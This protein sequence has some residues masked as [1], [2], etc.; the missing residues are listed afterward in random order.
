MNFTQFLLILR[1]RYRIILMTLLV[2]V[3]TTLVVSLLLPKTY[4]AST[5]LVLNY[6]GA[7]AVTGMALPAQLMPGYMPTQID[8][9][10]SRRVALKVV[11]DL[12]LAEG[13]AVQEQ[14]MK[15]VDGKG[16]VRDWLADA[17]L[18]GVEVL[19]SRE[20]SVLDINY[21]ATDPQFAAAIAN[22]F[23]AAYQQISIQLKVEPAQKAS[24]YFNEQIKQLREK[25]EQA[26]NKLSTYQQEHGIVSADNRLDVESARLNELS[27]QLVMAQGQSME[28]G[29][30]QRQAQSA[31]ASSPDVMANPL[32]QNIKVNLSMAEVKFAE[33]SQKL[34]KNHPQYQSA[35]SEVDKLRS[36]LEEQIKLASNGVAGNALILQQREAEIRAALAAQKAKV[37]ALAGTRDEIKV[38]VNEMET[39]QRAYEGASLR[40]NQTNME[41]QSNQ[42][43]IA[44]LNPAVAPL[45]PA[46]PKVL[47]NTLVSVFLGGVLGLGFAMLAELMNRRVR[48]A[49]DLLEALKVPVLGEI[50]WNAV[51]PRRMVFFN[52]ALS[53]NLKPN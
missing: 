42:T 46:G 53:N 2:T 30:R 9:I 14:F 35:K 40:F 16:N 28:A 39:A 29:S 4:K 37:I 15:A 36:N 25:L 48:S 20:S 17:L 6:K 10:T 33:T 24:G 52:R 47:L 34:D 23:A 43:D 11:D 50:N 45:S 12:N 5:S 27:S 7:D 18:K 1:A 51:K 3:V 32:V 49:E 19:P 41:G 21:K 13:S 31:N 22:A 8:I 44:V 26:Q 38:L